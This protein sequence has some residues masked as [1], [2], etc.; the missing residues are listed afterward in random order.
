MSMELTI[1]SFHKSPVPP[2]SGS[3]M[4]QR[5]SGIFSNATE[6]ITAKA[7]V[8]ASRNCE[9]EALQTLGSAEKDG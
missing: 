3:H 1:W 9:S 6:A 2:W 8:E 5:P 7:A 4:A